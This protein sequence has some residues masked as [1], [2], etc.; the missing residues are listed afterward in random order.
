MRSATSYF[1][2]TL[3]R[4]TMARFWPLWALWGLGWMFL[5]PLRLL[6]LY[7]SYS[8]QHNASAH[9]QLL[10]AA[11]NTP[12]VLTPCAIL[13]LFF[14]VLC[15]MAVF[16]HLYNSRSA[17]W[18]HALPL[19]REALFTTQY[20]AGLSFLLLPL[21]AAG[22]LTAIVEMSFLPV[23][24]WG[25]VLSALLVCLL[26]Q[27]GVCVFFFSF[28][29]FCA[30]F[31]GHILALPAFYFILNWLVAG[32]LF[33]VDALLNEFYYGYIGTAAMYTVSEYCT[34][35]AALGRAV[36]WRWRYSSLESPETV[37]AYAAVGA[38]LFFAALMVYRRRH[39]E[40]AGDV[41]A[42]SVVRPVFKYG[43]AFCSGLAFGMFTAAFFNFMSLS[44]LIPCILVWTVIGYFAA[45]MMLKKSFRVWK[46]W[47]GGAAVTGVMLVL[48]LVCFLD[49][50]G[51]VER[52]PDPGQVVSVRVDVDMGY[53]YDGG[54]TLSANLT[55]PAQI[56]KIV[57]LHQAIV[58]N[59]DNEDRGADSDSDYT[60]AYLY[61]TLSG[62]GRLDRRYCSV[63]LCA[64]DLDT[65]GTVAFALMQLLDDRGL[66]A[67]AYGFDGFLEDARLTSA[68]LDGVQLTSQEEYDAPVYLDDYRQELWDAVQ[69]DFAE[70]NIGV[71]WPF[72][73]N[74]TYQEH[75]YSARLIFEAAENYSETAGE[76]GAYDKTVSS[77]RS[78]SL[79]ITL[80][81]DARHTLAVLDK[82]GIFEEG[83]TLEHDGAVDGGTE[84]VD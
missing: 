11:R 46:A 83:Y 3:Y 17:C 56:E 63:P 45:E 20:L 36:N 50:F 33:L 57:A 53:P 37:A 42:V 80:T 26:A 41:V 1:N 82:T 79:G 67:R 75:V 2:G 40:T 8:A 81:P 38:A 13:T 9:K 43:V 21:A 29:A 24:D 47:K 12:E 72:G 44:T 48:C 52:V 34:P 49:L 55:D 66:V 18:T 77:S 35:I 6:N 25:E 14:A 5:L 15:A 22:V 58:D 84:V 32:I 27:S 51:V 16:G 69:Q 65:P 78:M 7:F 19:R 30:M 10:D 70:G 73:F 71:R 39:V 64:E 31:T 68:Y 61:Y 59:R 74:R 23:A 54:R 60:S 76:A 28:A 4:K 62:G